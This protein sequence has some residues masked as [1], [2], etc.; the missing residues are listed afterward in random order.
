[1]RSFTVGNIVIVISTGDMGKIID[2]PFVEY[3]VQI[4]HYNIKTDRKL[5]IRKLFTIEYHEKSELILI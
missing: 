5:F 1:M 4:L 3:A 2:I